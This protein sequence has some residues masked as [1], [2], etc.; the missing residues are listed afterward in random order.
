M[1]R[2]TTHYQTTFGAQLG[3][4][5]QKTVIFPGVPIGASNPRP[6]IVSFQHLERTKSA[7]FRA[8]RELIWLETK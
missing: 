5:K 1:Q 6:D 7:L 4:G 3:R 8:L 2:V